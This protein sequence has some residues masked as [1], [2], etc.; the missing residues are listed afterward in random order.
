M[1]DDGRLFMGWTVT[2]LSEDGWSPG[3]TMISRLSENSFIPSIAQ[4]TKFLSNE[5]LPL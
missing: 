5:C 2:K 1:V 4:N 3:S